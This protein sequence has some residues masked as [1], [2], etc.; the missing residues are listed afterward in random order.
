MLVRLAALRNPCALVIPASVV[1]GKY[2]KTREI[3]SID[4]EQV[5]KADPHNI[6]EVQHLSSI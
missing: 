3:P 6:Q 1:F 5:A 4:F 2:E